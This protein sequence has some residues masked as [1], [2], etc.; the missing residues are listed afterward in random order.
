MEFSGRYLVPASPEAVW[1][2]I[3][4]PLVL[5]ACIPGC[6]KM[7]KTGPNDFEATAKLKIGPVSATFKGKVS[8][9]DL[10]PPHRC[11]LKGEGQG[12]VAGFARGEAEVL[13]TKEGDG[14]ALSYTAK[15]TV[16]GKLA[17]IGQRL[18]DGAAKQI[19]DDFFSRFAAT[20]GAPN[21]EASA[22]GVQGETHPV[23][24]VTQHGASAPAPGRSNARREGVAPEIWVVGLIAIIVILLAL[25]GALL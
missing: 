13:L 21:A 7:E 14:T 6:Q 22:A 20:V 25:F 12:G 17:Q 9:A 4:D 16:G 24:Q 3:N 1:A 19:A 5:Q 8:L 11:T 15:A 18:I 23:P 2:G 10:D